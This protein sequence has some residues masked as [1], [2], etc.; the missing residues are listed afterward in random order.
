MGIETTPN[1]IAFLRTPEERFANLDGFAFEPNYVDVDGLRMA[2]IDEGPRD[3][4]VML[5]LHGEP[6][7]SY[8]YRFMIPAFTTAGYRVIAPDLIGFGRSDKPTERSSYTYAGHVSW[9]T[10][11]ISALAI[12][13][14][15]VFCQDWGGLLGLRIVGQRP[16]LFD[17]VVIAN[18]AL[19]DGTNMGEGFAMWQKASQMMPF[20]DCGALLKRAVLARELSEAEM[21]S[22]RAPFPDESYMA[23]ARQFP[24]LV[25]TTADDPAVPANIEAWKVL[26][27]FTKPVLTLWAPDDVVLGKGQET[28]LARIP[29]TKDQPHQTFSPAGHF[30]QDDVGAE[31]AAAVISWIQS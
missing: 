8:L 12:S 27:A 16:D 30:L 31:I 2:Y 21:D 25:P 29:G 22:Y 3:G 26:E 13:N 6:S 19:P 14:L 4:L 7:W 5:C 1:G 11:F 24:M 23:G 9:L 17:R 20:M 18:T 28:F 15:T 10:S